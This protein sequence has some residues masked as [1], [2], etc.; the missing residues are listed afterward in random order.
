MVSSP[1]LLRIDFTGNQFVHVKNKVAKYLELT[2]P[3]ASRARIAFASLTMAV[4][5]RYYG[6]DL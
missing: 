2:P 1:F 5:E 4:M 3:A 6:P